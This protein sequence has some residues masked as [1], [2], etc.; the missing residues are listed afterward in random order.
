MSDP[1]LHISLRPAIAADAE[2][3]Y[4]V[5]ETCM[6]FYAEQIWGTWNEAGAREDFTPDKDLIVQLDGRDIGCVELEAAS[7]H[8]ELGKLYILPDWQNRGIGTRLLRRFIDEARAAGKPLRLRVLS[9]NPA[10]RL[11]ERMGFVVTQTTPE[12]YY[13]EWREDGV[14]AL[15]NSS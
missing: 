15:G 6:R 14:A 8:I 9:V 4:R 13:M 2:F 7:D 11:Y 3:V 5:T 12:R 10:R 1:S